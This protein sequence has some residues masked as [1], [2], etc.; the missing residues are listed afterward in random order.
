MFRIET[1][2]IFQTLVVAKIAQLILAII[3]R[4]QFPFLW[5]KSSPRTTDRCK[6]LFRASPGTA[7]AHPNGSRLAPRIPVFCYLEFRDSHVFVDWAVG[8][9][10][11]DGRSSPVVSY[12]R[13]HSKWCCGFANYWD[14][15]FRRRFRWDRHRPQL[16][17][18]AGCFPLRQ[19]RSVSWGEVGVL[20]ASESFQN[21]VC[22]KSRFRPQGRKG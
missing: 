20:E 4:S 15:L 13:R 8:G 5:T 10:E 11:R 1:L 6:S 16:I 18:F 19:I 7:D 9:Q 2:K 12:S 21:R 17:L 22:L 14:E 3:I